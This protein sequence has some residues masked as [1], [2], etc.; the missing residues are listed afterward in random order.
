MDK[1]YERCPP[2]LLYSQQHSIIIKF[3][4]FLGIEVGGYDLIDWTRPGVPEKWRADGFDG[5]CFAS[6]WVDYLSSRIFN[7][8]DKT[9]VSVLETD[10][11]IFNIC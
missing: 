8:F 2:I 9:G 7:F 4:V 5:A 3:T 11:L 6:G 1:T 10:G